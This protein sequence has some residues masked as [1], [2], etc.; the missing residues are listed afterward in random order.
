[1]TSACGD[2]RAV[3]AAERC[4]ALT[5]A[6]TWAGGS[7]AGAAGW[8]AAIRRAPSTAVVADG[9]RS[10]LAPAASRQS[11]RLAALVALVGALAAIG[12]P[13]EAQA[14][15][16][17]EIARIGERGPELVSVRASGVSCRAARRA[18]SDQVAAGRRGWTCSSAGSEAR[19]TKGSAVAVY[20]PA[21]GV[22]R[23][24]TVTF[25]R[26][27]SNAAFGITS[28]RVSCRT[29]RGVARGARRHGPSR[30][31]TYRSRGFRCRSKV[32]ASSLPTALFTC[33]RGRAT[34]AFERA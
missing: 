10:S 32:L 31:R 24:G 15:G 27:T 8:L 4:G 26:N 2:C 11:L 14:K 33:R 29:G 12:G 6:A 22:R 17:G 34:V 16:C 19:C 21:R 3:E 18:L 30:P 1:M 25:R 28:K 13:A 9:R 7:R 23:C 5:T 20:L